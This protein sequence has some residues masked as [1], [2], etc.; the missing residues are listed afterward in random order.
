MEGGCLSNVYVCF[1]H[2]LA[3][4]LLLALQLPDLCN[5]RAPSGLV[6]PYWLQLLGDFT[7]GGDSN[8]AGLPLC[9]FKS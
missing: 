1:W 3:W 2:L 5:A 9:R 6:F 4:G 8:A 7:E